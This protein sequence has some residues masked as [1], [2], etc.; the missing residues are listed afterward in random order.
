LRGAVADTGIAGMALLLALLPL[1][2]CSTGREPANASRISC[3]VIGA[4]APTRNPFTALFAEDPQFTYRAYPLVRVNTNMEKQKLDRRYY[5]RTGGELMDNY[6]IM[7][8]CE[9]Q[10]EHFT[11]RKLHD[12][13]FA[14]REAGM[15]GAA[16]P[17]C[18]WDSAWVPTILYDLMPVSQ[19]Y[20]YVRSNPYRVIFRREMESVF[21]PFVELGMEKVSGNNYHYMTPRP[22]SVTWADMQPNDNPWL[23]SWRLGGTEAG[24]MWVFTGTFDA[25]WWGL[26]FGS[27][28]ENPYAIDMLTNLIFYSFGMPM[29]EDIHSRR[30]ARRVLSNFQAQKLLVLS[31]MEWA[32][33]FGA[34]IFPLNEDLTAL[35]R[36]ASS[37]MNYYLEQDYAGVITFMDSISSAIMDLSSEAVRLKDGAMA[38]AYLVEYFVVTSASLIAGSVLWSLMVRRRAYHAVGSTRLGII[39]EG[40]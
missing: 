29:V 23:V 9:A 16:S 17:G 20:D 4:V 2:P 1:L 38:W 31:M 35:E 32:D 37:A 19:Y 18:S 36:E 30:E 27:G 10:I 34:N 12:L 6:D 40:G 7:V 15:V 39:Y 14:F 28:G 21:T 13:D 24:I 11:P 3:F 26:V 22:G 25:P 33:K 5:P 8:F